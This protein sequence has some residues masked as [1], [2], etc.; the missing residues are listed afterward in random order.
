VPPNLWLPE[1]G[2]DDFK[3]SVMRWLDLKKHGPRLIANA[4]DQAPPHACEDRIE[5]MRDLVE[6]HG[7]Y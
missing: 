6:R 1:A 7:R 5:I 2:L 4:G 3:A